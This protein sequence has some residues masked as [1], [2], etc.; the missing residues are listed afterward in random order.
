MRFLA[1]PALALLL[2]SAPTKAQP[3]SHDN[4]ISGT[5]ID[6]KTRK[7]LSDVIVILRSHAL[8]KEGVV[9]VYTDAHGTFHFS[10]L[11]PGRYGLGFN[12]EH[13]YPHVREDLRLREGHSLRAR[14]ELTWNPEESPIT[15]GPG[16]PI[17]D[18]GSKPGAST[19][20]DAE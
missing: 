4:T 7:P 12:H 10:R 9:F 17:R 18:A 13:Y 19:V 11:P 6:A 3:V 16:L 5:V 15:C 1:L 2:A 8:E 14:A 20:H